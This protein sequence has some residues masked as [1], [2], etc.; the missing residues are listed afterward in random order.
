MGGEKTTVQNTTQATSTPTPT[1][2]ETALNKLDLERRQASQSGLM[3]SDQASLDLTNAFLR[4]QSLPG[5]FGGLPGGIS[6]DVTTGIVNNSLRDLNTQMAKSGSGTFL[7]SGASQSIGAR[8]AGEIR[9]NAEEFNLG[10]L[11]NL[12]NLSI[13]SPA[14]IQQPINQNAALYSSRLAGLRSTTSTGTNN[15]TTI[16][17]NP[18]LKSFQQSAGQTLGSPSFSFGGFGF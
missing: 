12:L 13:G 8:T 10:Q 4:G 16:G 3:A 9:M 7:E 6:P 5:Y 15:Q 1:A 17:M 2:E 18:F 11:L 14:Q